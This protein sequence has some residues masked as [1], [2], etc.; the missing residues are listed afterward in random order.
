M[1]LLHHKNQVPSEFFQLHLGYVQQLE[2]IHFFLHT[3]F[4]NIHLLFL[5]LF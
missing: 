2:Y 1:I 5:L 3:L 4:L